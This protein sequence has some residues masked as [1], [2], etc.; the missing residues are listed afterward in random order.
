M[1]K[2]SSYLDD[3]MDGRRYAQ[4]QDQLDGLR[5]E[6]EEVGAKIDTAQQIIAFLEQVSSRLWFQ[7]VG[8]M[9]GQR[10]AVCQLPSPLLPR[11]L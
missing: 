2:E 8:L 3:W 11:S 9:P 10:I 6:K 1:G 5:A 7:A 4:L